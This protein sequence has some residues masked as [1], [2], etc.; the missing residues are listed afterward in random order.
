MFSRIKAFLE[1]LPLQSC[2][3]TGRTGVLVPYP[4]SDTCYYC[5]IPS[6]GEPFSLPPGRFTATQ[7]RLLG[8]VQ[9]KSVAQIQEA[10][11]LGT[12]LRSSMIAGSWPS[13]L[14]PTSL[15]ALEC[16]LSASSL[17]SPDPLHHLSIARLMQT[18][19]TGHTVGPVLGGQLNS[20][21]WP[22]L[23]SGWHR[24]ALQHICDISWLAQDTCT[25]PACC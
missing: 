16:F 4:V 5:T 1:T 18:H 15:P 13:L 22:P 6:H 20:L 2:A 23:L 12:E 19:L 7:M 11:K 17:Y 8:S 25:S 14:L 21:H 9:L 10:Q 3:G 24:H